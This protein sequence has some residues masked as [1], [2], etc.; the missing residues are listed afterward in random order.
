MKSLQEILKANG[1]N[2]KQI[3][4]KGKFE[5]NKR[6]GCMVYNPP[7]CNIRKRKRLLKNLPN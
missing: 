6:A 5:Y 3:F 7:G 1:Q 4:Q 2:P